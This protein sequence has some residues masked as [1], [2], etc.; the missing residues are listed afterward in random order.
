V[1]A[2]LYEPPWIG[3]VTSCLRRWEEDP[4]GTPFRWTMGRGTFFVPSNATT[5]TVPLRALFPGPNGKPVVVEI[6][7]D[8]RLLAT[9]DLI[10]PDAWV[11]KPLP[12]NRYTGRRRFRRVDLRVSRV[13]PPF[14]L[15]VMAGAVELR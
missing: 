12:L 11:R 3:G 9:I 6:R 7:V 8:G 2:Y 4:P 5:M 10:E 15:G 1:L 13:V 14:N